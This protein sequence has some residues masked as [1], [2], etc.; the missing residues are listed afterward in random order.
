MLPKAQSL[1]QEEEDSALGFLILGRLFHLVAPQ[2][3][4]DKHIP[5]SRCS[6]DSTG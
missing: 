4:T 3:L 5:A 2:H 1:A 6:E